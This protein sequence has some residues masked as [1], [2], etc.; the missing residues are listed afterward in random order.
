MAEVVLNRLDTPVSQGFSV[1]ASDDGSVVVVAGR[2]VYHGTDHL[3]ITTLDVPAGSRPASVSA[4]GTIIVIGDPGGEVRPE[5][6]DTAEGRV[7]VFS[8]AEWGT[9]DTL[10]PVYRNDTFGYDWVLSFG[11]SVAISADNSTIAVGAAAVIEGLQLGS[12]YVYRWSGSS[13]DESQWLRNRLTF[14]ED[15]DGYPPNDNEFGWV[16]DV[17]ADGS[18]VAVGS[19]Q[20]PGGSYIGIAP[21]GG[22]NGGGK[23]YVFSDFSGGMTTWTRDLTQADDWEDDGGLSSDE[24]GYS[25]ALSRDGLTM[26][27]GAP[28][29][30]S[31]YVMTNTGSWAVDNTIVGPVG[32][33]YAT[34]VALQRP[35]DAV[36]YVGDYAEFVVKSYDLTGAELNT[37]VGEDVTDSTFYYAYPGASPNSTILGVDGVD[38]VAVAS[39]T[40]AYV[41]WVPPAAPD[42]AHFSVHVERRV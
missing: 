30:Y 11:R 37:Y 26:A 15:W 27:V 38:M 23:A 14:G 17:S 16:V 42:I 7:Y 21:W 2:Y 34:S 29:T 5:R 8:G 28:R 24:F 3:Q 40:G 22:D 9:K 35:S 31:V 20:N 18:V 6:D 33:G 32:Y 10:A 41:W 4:D 13:W 19:P 36:I 1:A 12:V 25:V 39:G